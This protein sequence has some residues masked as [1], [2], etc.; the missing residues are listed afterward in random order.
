MKAFFTDE[1]THK[2][3][4]LFLVLGS[5]YLLVAFTSFLFT[6]RIDQDL[7]GRSWGEIFSPEVQ[8][9]NWLGKLGAL[10]ANQFIYKWFGIAAFGLVLWSFLAGVRIL[11]GKWLLPVKRTL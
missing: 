11:L 6:W 7:I 2:V 8:A 1:R 3:G 9:E 4:G 10:T 5:A